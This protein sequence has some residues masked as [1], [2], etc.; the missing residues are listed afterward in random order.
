MRT[1][2]APVARLGLAALI[3]TSLALVGTA[4]ANAAPVTITVCATGCDF[5]AIQPALDAAVTGDT[6]SVAAGDY[7]GGVSI[8]TREIDH[9]RTPKPAPPGRPAVLQL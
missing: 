6:V 2:T 7:E 8:S 5:T 1:T 9:T 4:P 3:A